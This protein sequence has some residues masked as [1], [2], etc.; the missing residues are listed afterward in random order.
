MSREREI[1]PGTRYRSEDRR[2]LF[3]DLDEWEH[4]TDSPHFQEVRSLYRHRE[5]RDHWFVLTHASGGFAVLAEF[6]RS[7]ELAI[8]SG[9]HLASD[10]AADWCFAHGKEDSIPDDIDLSQRVDA[11]RKNVGPVCLA[12]RSVPRPKLKRNLTWYAWYH[13]NES[14]EYHSH[15]K[16]RD[17]WNRENRRD[18]INLDR[19]DH[20]RGVVKQ[21]IAMAGKFLAERGIDVETAL[22]ELDGRK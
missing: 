18:R 17:R 4:I 8:P 10:E 21:G 22:E 14:N 9:R 12:A 3:I 15:A 13:D 2:V 16:I 5:H 20:G 7:G 1:P 6:A 11:V 19:S